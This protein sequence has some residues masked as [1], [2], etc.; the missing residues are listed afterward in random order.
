MSGRRL[1]G[2]VVLI[3]GATSGIGRAAAQAFA[4]EGATVAVVG[5]DRP[6][7]DAVVEEIRAGGS[8]QARFFPADASDPSDIQRTVADVEA[9]HGRL[10]VAY[11]SAGQMLSGTAMETTVEDWRRIVD[12]NLGGPFF[13]AKYAIPA[14]ARAGG[15]VLVLTASELGTV[16][17]AQ[18]AAYCAVKGGV[19][20]LVRALAIDAAPLGVRVIGLAPG[21]VET[22]MLRD[23]LAA[24]P[25]PAEAHRAQ[26]EPVLLKRYGRPEEIAETA[27]FLASDASSYMTGTTLVV[28][29]GATAWYGM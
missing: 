22:P 1:A 20:N 2:K 12:V 29:G 18:A 19:I 17:A 8:G 16:G 28:D 9:W 24:A 5:R 15:G 4:R 11:Q 6:R 21:P 14:L 26:T 13:L 10:D 7:G 25:D 27:V 23:W 3:T